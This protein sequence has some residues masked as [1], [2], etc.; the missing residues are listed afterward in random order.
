MRPD[1][2]ETPQLPHEIMQRWNVAPT[3]YLGGRHN[4]HWLV[5]S[6]GSRL[7]VRGYSPE[8]WDDI[9]YEL[10]VLRQLAALGWPVPTLVE[11][12]THFAGQTWCLFTW[13]PG[14]PPELADSSKERRARGR[15][16]AEL[17]ES[18]ALIGDMGQRG[19]FCRSDDLVGDPELLS[20]VQH[21]ERVCPAEGHI[22]RWHLDQARESFERIDLNGAETLVLHSD[23]APWNLLLRDERL[24][25]VL[26]FESTHLNYRV[27]DFA[28]AWRGDQDEILDGYQ[29]VHKLTDLD[30]NLLVPV[31][32]AWMFLGVKKGIRAM[33][34]GALPSPNFDWQ[35]KHLLKHS[36]LV[37]Q[38]APPYPGR[39]GNQTGATL[40]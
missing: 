6:R 26:D 29:E 27:A 12:P 18:T 3:D 23:F 25:G 13:L 40:E 17:H 21:Y 22:L 8:T 24:S 10:E 36:G 30:W 15:L 34:S 37:G 9:A 2:S 38:L 11:P 14:A 5:Q 28:L 7:V 31:Y 32:W 16:L 33:T 39:A 1:H 19:G 20:L 35:I 4:Q